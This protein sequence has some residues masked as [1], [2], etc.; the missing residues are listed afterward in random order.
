MQKIILLSIKP[1]FVKEILNGNKRIE[2]RR[3]RPN[4]SK[5]DLMIFYSTTPQCA[6]CG[7]ARVMNVTS[8]N[9][10]SIWKE[11]NKTLG[12]SQ[13][14]FNSYFENKKTAFALAFNKVIRFDKEIKLKEIQTKIK[15]FRAPQSYRYLTENEMS[16]IGINGKGVLI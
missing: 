5:N 3:T 14:A 1:E 10:A 2:L 12:I 4:I 7:S 9:P 16:K 8:N 11:H 6:I 13:N 15:N